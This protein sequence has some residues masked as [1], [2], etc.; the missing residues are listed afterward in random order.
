[1]DIST[2]GHL[3]AMTCVSARAKGGVERRDV[4]QAV[5]GNLRMTR[6]ERQKKGRGLEPSHVASGT[7]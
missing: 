7:V 6:P 3:N 4:L 5:I 2:H 1:M